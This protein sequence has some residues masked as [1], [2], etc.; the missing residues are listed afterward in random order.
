MKIIIEIKDFEDKT[1]V[2][3]YFH[4]MCLQ[5]PELEAFT[6]EI[7]GTDIRMVKKK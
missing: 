5:N 1:A 3:K 6:V 7:E 2:V 4:S